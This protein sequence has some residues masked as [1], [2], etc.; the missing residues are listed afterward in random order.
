MRFPIASS[1]ARGALYGLSAVRASF[2][3]V[4]RPGVRTNLTPSDIVAIRFGVAG[5][6]LAPF[7]LRRG[8]WPLKEGNRREWALPVLFRNGG[9][10]GNQMRTTCTL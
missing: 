9:P 1:Y 4:S 8:L 7:L 2:V 10:C 3:V 6:I 5:V